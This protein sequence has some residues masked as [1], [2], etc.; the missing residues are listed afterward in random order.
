MT[1]TLLTDFVFL[2][3]AADGSAIG[4]SVAGGVRLAPAELP[5]GAPGLEGGRAGRAQ[6]H[7]RLARAEAGR[8]G[9]ADGTDGA[10]RAAA[11]S[12]GR[13]DAGS[14]RGDALP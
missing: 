11:G 9:R 8:R 12:F 10:E 1:K 6:A 2:G 4:A 14:P 5:G 13:R 3:P 7:V